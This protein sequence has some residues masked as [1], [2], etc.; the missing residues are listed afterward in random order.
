VRFFL[1]RKPARSLWSR[2]VR[3]FVYL[4]AFMPSYDCN[5]FGRGGNKIIV[6]LRCD[7]NK[8]VAVEIQVKVRRCM[9]HDQ[10]GIEVESKLLGGYYQLT[11]GKVFAFITICIILYYTY[12]WISTLLLQCT[13]SYTT[14]NGVFVWWGHWQRTVEN[15]VTMYPHEYLCRPVIPCGRSR[16]CRDDIRRP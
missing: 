10:W 6:S 13:S 9:F 14:T 1:G 3:A 11:Y 2:F 5:L 8:A 16:F 12:I 15:V 4:N 7:S